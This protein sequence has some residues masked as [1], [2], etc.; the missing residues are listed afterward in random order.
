[1]KTTAAYIRVSTFHQAN[2]AKSQE[3]ALRDYIKN[4]GLKNIRWYRDRITGATTDRPAFNKLQN[5]VFAGKIATVICWKLDRL[6][7]SMRDG[8]NILTD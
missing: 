6:S 4:Q 2:G 5:D 1:M 8:V 7:R 3:K